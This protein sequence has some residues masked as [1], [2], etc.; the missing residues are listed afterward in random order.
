MLSQNFINKHLKKLSPLSIILSPISLIWAAV[1]VLRRRNSRRHNPYKADVKV[2]SVG[3]ITSGG[4]GKTPFTIF[5]AKHLTNLGKKVA[6][7]HRGYKGDYEN[8]NKIISDHSGLLPAAQNAGDEA[9]LIAQNLPGISVCVGKNRE[10]SIRMLCRHVPDLDIVILDDSFQNL[11]VYH[12]LDFVI[13]KMPDPIGNGLCIPAGFLREPLSA[14]KFADL[15]IIN[16]KGEL[17]R[18][19]DSLKSDFIRGDYQFQ[20]FFLSNKAKLNSELLR[21][22]KIGIVSGIAEP[23][24]LENTLKKNGFSWL[25]HLKFPDHHSYQKNSDLLLIKK[26]A[27][28]HQID[29]LITTEKDYVKLRYCHLNLKICTLRIE[30]LPDH[31]FKIDLS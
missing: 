11:K 14:L 19:F 23:Q 22:S 25:F 3:N 12:D 24:S 27:R 5:L 18:S 31:P 15:I 21:K 10:I 4:S 29:Y 13:F 2:I 20:G 26:F 30:F 6:I 1:Q 28:M 9:V 8:E 17:P 7:S 16:G